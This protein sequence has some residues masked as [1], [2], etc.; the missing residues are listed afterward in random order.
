MPVHSG[1]A[2]RL[3]SAS[4]FELFRQSGQREIKT[5]TPARLKAKIVR[6]RKLRDKSRDLAAQQRGEARG[7]RDPKGTR[8]ASNNQRTIRKAEILGIALERFETRL[9]KL[10]EERQRMAEKKRKEAERKKKAAE[11]KRLDAARKKKA[12]Q[13]KALQKASG[14]S[15]APKTGKTATRKTVASAD[16]APKMPRSVAAERATRGHQ[17][18]AQRRA[19]ARRDKRG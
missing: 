9:T 6:A 12:A 1:E 13:R 2:K 15:S 14:N 11:K 8:P 17:K 18:S 19:Q 16:A 7:K 3:L 10:E 4:E 5:L